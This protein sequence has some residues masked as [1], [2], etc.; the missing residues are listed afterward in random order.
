[1]KEEWECVRP[2]NWWRSR[3]PH[4]SCLGAPGTI[5]K[6]LAT[7][8]RKE[9]E[10][11][12]P[13]G[14]QFSPGHRRRRGQQRM[15]WLDGITNSM[16]MN[17]SELWELVKDREA[18]GAAVHGAAKSLTR[19]SHWTELSSLSQDKVSEDFQ[20]LTTPP[21]PC[22]FWIWELKDAFQMQMY[23]P[24]GWLQNPDNNISLT[25]SRLICQG[26]YLSVGCQCGSPEL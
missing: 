20:L 8:Y 12:F 4:S 5:S 26:A 9:I 11:Q 23:A 3:P 17:L 13:F 25:V 22:L 7:A 10:S 1:M 15:K 18:W 2:C 24:G 6:E 14:D 21:P 16:D 19:L